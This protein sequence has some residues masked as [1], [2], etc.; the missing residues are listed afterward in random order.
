MNKCYRCAELSGCYAGLHGKGK[1]D[2]KCFCPCYFSKDEK[3]LILV[4]ESEWQQLV[5]ANTGKVL[6]ENHR[7]DAI[8]VLGALG[9]DFIEVEKKS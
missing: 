4:E 7:L 5:D 6:C 1:E 8:D 3:H 2:C 9:I